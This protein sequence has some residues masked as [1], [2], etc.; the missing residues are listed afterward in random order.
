M[1]NGLFG[2]DNIGFHKFLSYSHY[3]D[4]IIS[5]T[6]N[7]KSVIGKNITNGR[8]PISDYK[9]KAHA[10]EIGKWTCLSCHWNIPSETSYVYCNGKQIGE[11]TAVSHSGSTQMTFADINPSGKAGLNGQIGAFM[12]YKNHRM[13]ERD[14]LLHHSVLCK[15]YGVD[16][17]VITF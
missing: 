6:T 14:I 8:S 11:F 9:P 15:W 4:L 17:D 7:D 13:K 3:G 10:G 12:L 2:N 16:H 5:S 1:S